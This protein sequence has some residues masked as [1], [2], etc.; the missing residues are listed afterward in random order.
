MRAYVFTDASLSRQAGRFVWLAIN[1]EKAKNASI[2]KKFPI[3]ALPTYLIVDPTDETVLL[4]W[5]GSATIQQLHRMLDDGVLALERRRRKAPGDESDVHLALADSLYGAGQDSAAAEHYQ[6]ALSSAAANWRSFPR[7]TEALLFSLSQ[8]DA[9]ER[10]ASTAFEA[11]PR[12]AGTP[13]GANVAASGLGCAIELPADHPRRQEWIDHFEAAT[14]KAVADTSLPIAG[15]DRSGLYIALLDARDAAKDSVGQ[16][17]VAREWASF[18][19]SAAARAPTPDAR[20]VFDSHRL[21]A[22]IEIDEP[23]RAIPM[24]E[25]SERDLPDD[26]N[27]PARLATAYK[28]LSRWKEALAASDRAMAKAYGPRKILI[29]RTRADIYLGAGDA[30]GARRTLDEAI[31]HAESLPDGQRNP[32]TIEALK[33]QRDGI[34]V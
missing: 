2:R 15:D 21:S 18:L 8:T 23:E 24:L 3:P 14:R 17:Q 31:A 13:S 33:K 34:K 12:L 6:R 30:A 25:A 26:Y 27:P 20:A 4:R 1:S 11:Y 19:E 5:V 29:Y 7:A 16:R 28:A 22:Y 9:Y 10:C 32:R